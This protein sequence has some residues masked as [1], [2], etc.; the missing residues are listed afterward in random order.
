M[1][2]IKYVCFE[3]LPEDFIIYSS[4]IEK[5]FDKI[6][7]DYSAWTDVVITK[8][9]PTY[10]NVSSLISSYLNRNRNNTN[11][12][13]IELEKKQLINTD[14]IY[15]I[16][17]NWSGR[18][19]AGSTF[20]TDFLD[21]KQLL[22]GENAIVLTIQT[23]PHSTHGGLQFLNKEDA[24]SSINHITNKIEKTKIF[25]DIMLQYE[26]TYT[27]EEKQPDDSTQWGKI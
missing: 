21:N 27:R 8:I 1:N 16:D 7:A 3:D 9:L 19:N 25:K 2:Q 14:I 12:F 6:K 23:K 24:K 13:K 26:Q 18:D 11:A 17:D 10:D 4:L 20:F 5:A 22:N 15:F